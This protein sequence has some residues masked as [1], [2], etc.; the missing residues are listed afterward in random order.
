MG[1]AEKFIKKSHIQILNFLE[2]STRLDLIGQKG[3]KK[4]N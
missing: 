2:L 3:T 4:S 1:L